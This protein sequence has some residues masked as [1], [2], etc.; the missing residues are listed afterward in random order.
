MRAIPGIAELRLPIKPPA[1]GSV[2]PLHSERGPGNRVS[3]S[4]RTAARP[5]EDP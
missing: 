4:V 3:R 2:C 5:V 1:D